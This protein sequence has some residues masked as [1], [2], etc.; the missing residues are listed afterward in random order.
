MKRISRSDLQNLYEPVPQRLMEDVDH[1]LSSLDDGEER[2]V[3][4][5]KISVSFVLA[6]VL[7]IA[8]MAALA[9]GNMNL[10]RS[11]T[12]MSEP[13]LPL[14]GA[15]EMI[16]T[17]LGSV[18]NEFVTLTVEEAVYDGQTVMALARITPRDTGKYAL[19][20][21]FLQDTPEEVY[22]TET[23]PVEAPD[24]AMSWEMDGVQYEYSNENGAVSLKVNGEETE[25][26]GDPETAEKTGIPM[27]I[28]N[29]TV[30]YA[31]MFDHVVTGRRDGRDI[32]GYWAHLI[33]VDPDAEGDEEQ[34]YSMGVSMDAEEQ[35]DGSVLVWFDLS[36]ELDAY[37]LPDTVQ[38]KLT[39]SVTADGQEIAL[40]D[41]IFTLDKSE[42]E[43]RLA[44]IPEDGSIAG[45]IEILDAGVSYSSVRGYLVVDYAYEAIESEPMGITL[46]L[47]DAEGN[48]IA[49]GSGWTRELGDGRYREQTQV[50][51]F[52]EIPDT[53]IL[54]AKA[55]DGSVIGSCVCRV[56]AGE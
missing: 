14:E 44:L 43:N 2:T 55:I 23:A 50:Q 54:E 3:V 53:L 27:Y 45:R 35:A 40:D 6:A 11:M 24:G 30:Y 32:L 19:L 37:T 4:K 25:L 13:I 22:N 12:N 31:D 10:F 47:K 28:E 16:R 21:S 52:A 20:N 39:C 41:L 49:D 34:G 33:V 38:M 26:P 1:V 51:A 9:A 15:E 29:G 8:S 46:H 42:A 36:G 17:G 5:K 18:E 48:L 7:I 56:S